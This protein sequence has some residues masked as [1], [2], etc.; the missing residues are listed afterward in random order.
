MGL[1]VGWV[2]GFLTVSV[3]LPSFITTLGTGFILLGLVNTTS[4][5][6]AVP[7]PQR[8]GRHRALDR[9]RHLVRV[10]LGR[11]HA[12]SWVTSC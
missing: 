3:G 8:R 6:E 9:L 11:H 4:H 2:N 7:I 10:H 5:A 12:S 1:A